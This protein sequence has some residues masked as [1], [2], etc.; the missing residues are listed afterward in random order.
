M[1][2]IINILVFG[3]LTASAFSQQLTTQVIDPT[4]T[5]TVPAGKLLKSPFIGGGSGYNGGGIVGLKWTPEGGSQVTLFNMYDNMILAGP[6]VLAGPSSPIVITY[7]IIDN[8]DFSSSTPTGIV[9]IPTDATG[10]VNIILE[11]STDLVTWTAATPG[12]YGSSTTKR[13]FRTR[14]VNQ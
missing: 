2:Y 3:I 4:R 5:I 10:P 14:A 8:I 7:A 13:F 1:N 6:G 11:S 9:V 12:T